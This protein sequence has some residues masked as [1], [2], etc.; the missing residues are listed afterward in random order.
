[1][2]KNM[3]CPIFGI[4]RTYASTYFV[5]V[6]ISFRDSI[7]MSVACGKQIVATKMAPII[8]FVVAKI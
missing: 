1:M 6:A 4:R 3:K 5:D 7:Y 2:K 8:F